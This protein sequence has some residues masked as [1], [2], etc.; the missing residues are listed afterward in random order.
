LQNYHIR[1]F[2]VKDRIFPMFLSEKPLT[3]ATS[4][5][6]SLARIGITWKNDNYNKTDIAC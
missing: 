2:L 5:F 1:I 3:S 6:K 4:F